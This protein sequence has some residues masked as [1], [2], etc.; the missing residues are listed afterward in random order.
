VKT[1][2]LSLFFFLF[3]ESEVRVEERTAEVRAVSL[4]ARNLIETSLDPLV[5]ISK[6]GKI[7]DV[8][9]ANRAGDRSA[10]RAPDRQ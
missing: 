6:D 1:F 7:T 5:T 2:F 4:Y 3:A 9:H 8:N 10:A